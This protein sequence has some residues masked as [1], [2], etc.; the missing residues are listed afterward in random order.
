MKFTAE[1]E[2][3]NKLNFLNITIHMIPTNWK[4]S[5]YRKPT[6]TD[7]IIPYSSNHPA[8]HKYAAIRFLH[9]RPNTYHLQKEEYNDE[10][11][12]IRDIMSNNGFP[13]HTHK[14]PSIGHPTN[15]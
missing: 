14:P 7:T 15:P 11:N 13:I 6:F 5:V 9:S 4:I 8:Q 1:T 2:S 10:L 12:I 3:N